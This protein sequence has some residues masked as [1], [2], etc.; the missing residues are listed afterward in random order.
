MFIQQANFDRRKFKSLRQYF[1]ENRILFL[2]GH[3][4]SSGGYA[5]LNDPTLYGWAASPRSVIDQII[6]LDTVA[7]NR[8]ITLVVDS[9]GGAV[10]PFLRLYDVIQAAISPIY[11]IGMGEIASAAIPVLTG[12]AAGKRFIFKNSRVMMH[13]PEG[14]SRGGAKVMKRRAEQIS[15]IEMEYTEI[16]AKHTGHSAEEILAKI[17]ELGEYWMSAKE[18]LDFGIVDHIINNLHEVFV[19]PP[20]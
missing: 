13:S 11:T 2:E 17:E 12:G 5:Y 18:S 4:D 1:F 10:N 3:M 20:S 8:P 7:N 9:P 19:L 14:G 16:I 15:E 6:Y